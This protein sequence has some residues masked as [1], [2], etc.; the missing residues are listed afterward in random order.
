MLLFFIKLST[1]PFIQELLRHKDKSRYLMRLRYILNSSLYFKK[2]HS[3]ITPN[4]YQHFKDKNVDNISTFF[5]KIVDYPEILENED[6]SEED[7][8]I[9]CAIRTSQVITPD[10]KRFSCNI[11]TAS[12]ET[13]VEYL[14]N[15]HMKGISLVNVYDF[16]AG[17]KIINRYW[18]KYISNK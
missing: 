11:L 14:S 13:K 15:K 16:E 1:K 8:I 2:K 4:T 7:K 12:Y 10:K 3:L 18:N 17:L 5:S 6:L 9:L